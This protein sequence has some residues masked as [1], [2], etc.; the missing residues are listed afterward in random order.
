MVGLKTLAEMLEERAPLSTQESW[1]N[2]GWQIRL[3][4]YENTGISKVLVALE[5]NPAVA[6]EAIREKVQLI[7]CHHPLIFGGVRA[8]DHNEFTGNMIIKLV[9]A[10]I[11]VYATH[12][13]FDKCEGG[14]NDELAR[15]L[16]LMDVQSI[17][18]DDSGICRMGKLNTP[19][20]VKD[21]LRA[22]ASATGQDIRCYRII[23]DGERQAES[24]GICTGAGAEFLDL[25]AAAGCDLFVTGDVK[26]HT[27]HHA[28][29]LGISVADLGHYGSEQIFTANMAGLLR[30]GLEAAGENAEILESQV[31]LNP[32]AAV[33]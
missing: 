17:P 10:G 33:E 4:N 3:E 19:A 32:F 8:V 14:N 26:Y 1:D 21:V 15:L 13:P 29:E 16:G 24:V 6:E 23:G 20:P 28:L 25:A 7:V 12:T 9:Q 30:K 11:S 18:G 27:A 2:S 31:C 5:L 22:Y